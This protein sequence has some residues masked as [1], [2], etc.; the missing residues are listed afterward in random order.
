MSAAGGP[1]SVLIADG[2][3]V[4]RKLIRQACEA[5]P[6]LHVSAEVGDADE[7]LTW[8][9]RRP[10]DQ[11]GLVALDLELPGADGLDLARRL[12]AD[13]PG[14]AI[15]ALAE[16]IDD[17]L[18]FECLRAGISGLLERSVGVEGISTA[19]RS[20]SA[21]ESA[22]EPGQE[23]AALRLLGRMARQ[24]REISEVASTI[25]A[26]EREVLALIS[27]GLSTRQVASRLNLSPKTV[28]THIGKLYR[29]LGARTRVQA[30][31][32]AVELGLIDL[33]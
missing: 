24:A 9:E 7:A 20:L 23:R 12:I 30:L 19:L 16:A 14:V 8:W 33:G 17:R 5:T 21:G 25:T 26:R 4:F 32:R 11:Q 3:P 13:A 29:K 1:T 22:F 31:S 28:E 18:V 2:H 6:P 10:S 15:L 27:E